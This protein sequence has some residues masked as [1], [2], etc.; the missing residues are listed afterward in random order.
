[1]GSVRESYAVLD[2]RA[3]FV[4]ANRG[5]DSQHKTRDLAS[6]AESRRP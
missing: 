1:M 6:N 5:A 2:P 4:A 3:S